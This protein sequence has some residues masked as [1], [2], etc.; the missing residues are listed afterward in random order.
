M[1][2]PILRLTLNSLS[3]NQRAV[4][5]ERGV[6]AGQPALVFQ[7]QGHLRLGLRVE[8]DDRL[9]PQTHYDFFTFKFHFFESFAS[10]PNFLNILFFL[11]EA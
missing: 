1:I 8:V 5:V 7:P 9:T 11:V 3:T 4:G 6:G 10:A 2:V